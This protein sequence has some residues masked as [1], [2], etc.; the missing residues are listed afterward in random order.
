MLNVTLYFRKN[1]PACQQTKED[2][3]ALQEKFPHHLLELDI[4]SDSVLKQKYDNQVPFVE[5]GPFKT[6]FPV[7][8]Q[9]LQMVVGAAFDRNMQIKQIDN[10]GYM[11]NAKR[12]KTFDF[13]DRFSFWIARHYLAGLNILMLVY[14]GLPLL[15]PT[16]MHYGFKTPAAVIYKVYSPLCHQFGFRSFFLFGAQPYYPL[17]EANIAG[18]KTFEEVTQFQ[19]LGN[20]YAVSRFQARQYIGDD[21]LGFKVALCERDTAIY[22]AIFLFGLIFWAVGRKL[23]KLHWLVWLVLGIGP[24]GLDGFS[25]LFSQF[26]FGWLNAIL[27]Y[28]ESTPFLRVLTGALFG[29]LTAWFAYPSIE[30]SMNETRQFYLKKL[31]AIQALEE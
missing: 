30:E 26:N 27:P 31:A 13:G 10:K 7:T 14:F 24:I 1:D 12:V 23:P 2:L 21:E 11:E 5:A 9:N 25:Q 28:R 8:K 29:G 20:P 19:D 16:L 15:A 18:V 3:L 22:S 17:A 4:D 6:Q